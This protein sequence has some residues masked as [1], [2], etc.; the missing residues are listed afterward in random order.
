M[1][2]QKPSDSGA[3]RE[4]RP[5]RDAHRAEPRTTSRA[6]TRVTWRTILNLGIHPREISVGIRRQI[7]VITATTLLFLGVSCVVGIQAYAMGFTDELAL[8]VGSS[9]VGVANLEL[10]RRLRRP[11]LA[12]H[13]AI[14]ILFVL[15]GVAAYTAG[16]FYH[17]SF[18]WTYIVPLAAAMVVNM[19]GALLWMLA[20]MLLSA[21]YWSATEFGLD[22]SLP[23]EEPAQRVSA[24]VDRIMT[25]SAVTILGLC[26]GVTYRRA[27]AQLA[28]DT[29][30]LQLMVS[31]AIAANQSP[32][33]SDA[34]AEAA[35][36]I[37]EVLNWQRSEVI[38]IEQGA[39]APLVHWRSAEDDFELPPTVAEASDRALALAMS[40]AQTQ[41]ET[42]EVGERP[43][44][45]S[46]STVP[47]YLAVVVPV[48][49]GGR[50]WGAIRFVGAQRAL[51]VEND[52]LVNIFAHVSAQLAQVARR[53]EL[54]SRIRQEQKMAAV[55]NL[56]AGMAHEINNP[57]AFVRS[58]LHVLRE[59]LNSAKSVHDLD[60]AECQAVVEESLEG[61]E[62]AVGIVRDV[63][64]FSREGGVDPTSWVETSLDALVADS[65]RVATADARSRANVDVDCRSEAMLVCAPNAVRQVCVN[66]IINALHSAGPDGEV[67]VA[68]RAE[69]EAL[70][71]S[72]DDDGPGV[73]DADRERIFEPFFTT[74]DVGS[75][76]GLGLSI[77][78]EI[79]ASH[80]GDL[81][82]SD[83]RLGG[84][85]FEV[86]LPT[87]AA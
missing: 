58:N 80:G 13:V 1:S 11:I 46:L 20:T 48:R 65:V 51:E 32:S 49:S 28:E 26:F 38:E 22:L 14:S 85:R 53:T 16:G 59:D 73:P 35:D 3:G 37:R 23:L 69:A 39:V 24:L 25:I 60:L 77:S 10:L 29:R 50:V 36:R 9:L 79:V 61:V 66:L 72:V 52:V 71:I 2:G 47:T 83:S 41:I 74:K 12:G 19:R 40:T 30:F 67:R 33:L 15:I 75:G 84:A 82:V 86:R 43:S 64:A 78:F 81:S 31:G 55:G 62:R 5:G 21:G 7:N 70:V 8:L 63:V 27:Q 17:P 45:W 34:M 57:M 68:T 4:P 56:A 76:T 42:V 44:A 18:A 54:E 87:E 6:S